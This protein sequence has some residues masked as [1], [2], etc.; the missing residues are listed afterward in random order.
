MSQNIQARAESTD[1]NSR[2]GILFKRGTGDTR[3]P[4]QFAQL[5]WGEE[6][7]PDHLTHPP[8]VEMRPEDA[9]RLMDD[10]WHAGLRPTQGKQSEGV[11]AAQ[12]AH[13]NDM[14]AIVFAK[15]EIEKP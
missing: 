7:P 2:V 15:L 1:Y 12:Q 6:N 5:A 3:D 10:L 8:T 14:R 4:L 9:Q 13:L 11:T